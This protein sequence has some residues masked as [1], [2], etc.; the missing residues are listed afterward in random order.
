[1]T[2][3]K[4]RITI[5]YKIKIKRLPDFGGIKTEATG[6]ERIAK[7]T[8]IIDWRLHIIRL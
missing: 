8:I 4:K 3:I 7:G 6:K 2:P 5:W 1:M